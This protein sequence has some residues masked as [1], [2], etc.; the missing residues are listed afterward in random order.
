MDATSFELT[1]SVSRDARLAGAVRALVVCAANYAGC[2]AAT[3]AAF[4]RDVEVAVEGS[5]QDVGEDGVVPVTVR[6]NAGPME[7]VVDG[8]VLRLEV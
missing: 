2:T 5:I 6:R 8:R 7:V 1:V 4:G 3:A